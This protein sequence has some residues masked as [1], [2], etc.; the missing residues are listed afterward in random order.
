MKY[1]IY[2]IGKK[3]NRVLRAFEFKLRLHFKMEGDK[4]VTTK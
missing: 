3:Q 1:K 2:T 4:Y